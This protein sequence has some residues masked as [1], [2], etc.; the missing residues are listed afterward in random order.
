MEN[1]IEFEKR[2]EKV[3]AY[4]QKTNNERHRNLIEKLEQE[5]DLWA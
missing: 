5:K 1:Q 3:K 4:S 2:M